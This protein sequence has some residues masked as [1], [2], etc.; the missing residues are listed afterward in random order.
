M[1]EEWRPLWEYP[2]YH[3][4]NYGDVYNVK[5]DRYLTPRGGGLGAPRV[6]LYKKGQR[7][8]VYVRDLVAAEFL[9]DWTPNHVIKHLDGDVRNSRADN[10]SL[11]LKR[12]VDPRDTDPRYYGMRHIICNET[13]EIF[14]DVR[15]AAEVLDLYPSNIYRCLRGEHHTTKGYSFNYIY[16]E[17]PLD[18]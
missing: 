7:T 18:Y 13:G 16:P 15:F 2:G 3:V 5:F 11:Y 10:L 17:D 14:S 6:V 12:E 8:E 1:R 9:N 4:S